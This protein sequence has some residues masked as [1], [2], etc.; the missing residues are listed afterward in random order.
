MEVTEEA[1]SGGSGCGAEVSGEKRNEERR[2]GHGQK[3]NGKKVVTW[4]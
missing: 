2:I 1:G 3:R 4:R